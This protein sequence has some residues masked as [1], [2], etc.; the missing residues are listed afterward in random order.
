M[1]TLPATKHIRL[2]PQGPVLHLWLNRPEARNALSATMVR[3]ISETFAAIHD[4]RSVR[5][6]VMRGAG[7]TFCAGGDIKNMQASGNAPPPGAEDELK[8]SNRRYGGM[9][10]MVNAAPQAVIAVVEGHAMGGGIGFA[11]VADITI[12]HAD[13]IFAMSEAL[14]GVVPAAI[15]PFVVQRVGLTVARRLAV[16]AA[17][18]DAQQAHDLG[19]VHVI[20]AD[21]VALE[22]ATTDAVNQ[23]LKCGPE[24]IAETKRL[25]LR[26]SGPTPLPTLLDLAAESFAGAVRGAEGREG[27]RAFV[28]K[29]KP[30]WVTRVK[31]V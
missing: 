7:G 16:T 1:S 29:R 26:A 10:E 5:V 21:V 28:E 18:F 11:S 2:Q 9:L 19:F 4:D 31:Q 27:T 17:R 30:A 24:A 12:A 14:L 13:A 8:A 25:M 6:V 23:V 20:A 22:I 15:S 3:E